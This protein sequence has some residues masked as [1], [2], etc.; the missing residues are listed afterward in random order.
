MKIE[1][2]LKVGGE[3]GYLYISQVNLFC[4]LFFVI[5]KLLGE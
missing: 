3:R 4:N 5:F 1:K 2:T